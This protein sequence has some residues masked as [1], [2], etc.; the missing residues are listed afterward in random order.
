M[1]DHGDD[2]AYRIGL[3]AALLNRAK[4]HREME[5]CVRY[6]LNATPEEVWFWSSKWLDE[7]LS[8]RAMHALAIMSG[9]TL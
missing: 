3:A 9:T 6:I 1:L 2:A 5:R 7:D 8:E 4:D